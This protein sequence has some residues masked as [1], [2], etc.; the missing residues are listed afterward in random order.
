MQKKT[1]KKWKPPLL[2]KVLDQSQLQQKQPIE[3]L[4]LP[5][6]CGTYL[7]EKHKVKKRIKCKYDIFLAYF[8]NSCTENK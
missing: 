8:N 2:I 6:K 3:N 5:E 4:E 7:F 1:T